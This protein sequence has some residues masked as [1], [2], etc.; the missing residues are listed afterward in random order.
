MK[1]NETKFTPGPWAC[2]KTGDGKRFIIGDNQST[3]GTHVAEV[4]RDDIDRDEAEANAALIRHA[5]ELF[6]AL[7]ALVEA[8]D[9]SIDQ[10]TAK[11]IDGIEAAMKRAR[12]VMDL[13][14]PSNTKPTD[15]QRSP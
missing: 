6:A 13:A 9:A 7:V 12:E 2:E 15:A 14:A 5:P 8:K 10:F 3:W 11:E 1:T 4:H